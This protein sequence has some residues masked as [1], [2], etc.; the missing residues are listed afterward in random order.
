[1]N[2][3]YPMWNM[4]HG[5]KQKISQML[6]VLRKDVNGVTKGKRYKNVGK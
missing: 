5:I 2:K 6:Q 4:I 1:M 3:F